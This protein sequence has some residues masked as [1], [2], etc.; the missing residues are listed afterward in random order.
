MYG[1][2]RLPSLP[3]WRMG[4]GSVLKLNRQRNYNLQLIAGDCSWQ[5]SMVGWMG[6]S[7]S[8]PCRRAD[9]QMDRYASPCEGLFHYVGPGIYLILC[10]LANEA[11]LIELKR[12]GRASND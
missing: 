2:Y 7:L 1:W 6:G 3:L 8:S 9:G 5:H 12:R 10:E 4:K 11:K